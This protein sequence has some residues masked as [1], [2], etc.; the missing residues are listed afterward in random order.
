[1]DASN[2]L[3]NCSLVC[4]FW[5]E[6]C[7]RVL[8]DGRRQ[9]I[10]S[11]KQAKAF[12]NVL[13]KQTSERLTPV[14]TFTRSVLV[15]MNPWKEREG[16]EP[17]WLHLLSGVPSLRKK[18]LQSTFIMDH[19]FYTFPSRFPLSS[20]SSPHWALPRSIPPSFTPYR[21]VTLRKVRFHSFSNF[22]K[23]VNHFTQVEAFDFYDV[24]WN[25]SDSDIIALRA[26]F[27]TRRHP[28]KTVTTHNC[29]D[30]VL[31]CLQAAKQSLVSKCPSL[32]WSQQAASGIVLA[33]RDA[34]H[35]IGQQISNVDLGGKRISLQCR[36]LRI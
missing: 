17:S 12:R 34:F 4:V 22:V 20:F 36:H 19:L 25:V 7:R 14:H 21:F 15:D 2:D 3:Q 29:T 26:T 30:N 6:H 10:Q 18:L 9:D 11:R 33:A 24:T 1:M 32:W 35:D 13:L 27:A 23:F 16:D 5:A 28:L 8:H 31:V